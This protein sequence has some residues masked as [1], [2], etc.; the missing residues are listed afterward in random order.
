MLD[1]QRMKKI[2]EV[3]EE[4]AFAIVEPGCELFRP[5]RLRQGQQ[6]QALD[7]LSCYRLG[8]R[9][10]P[11]WLSRIVFPLPRIFPREYL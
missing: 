4:S 11:L 2:I 10:F 8:Q 3:N 7:I 9:K 6:S 5:L 1:L